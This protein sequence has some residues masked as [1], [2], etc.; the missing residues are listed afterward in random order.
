MNAKT[1]VLAFMDPCVLYLATHD[2][3]CHKLEIAN[4]ERNIDV[5]AVAS[6][7]D[8]LS[9]FVV[10]LKVRVCHTGDPSVS[11]FLEAAKS[12]AGSRPIMVHMGRFPHTPS[13]ETPTLL[14]ALRGGDI[15]THA[16]R[17]ASGV[18]SMSDGQPVA[19]F[20]DAVDRGVLLDIGHSAT[21]FRFRDARR[22]VAAG[23]RPD[24]VSTDINI[25]NIDGPVISLHETMSKMLVLGFELGEVVAMTTVA[26]ATAIHQEHRYGTLGVGREAEISVLEMVE[27]DAALTDGFEK[28]VA[29]RR[30]VPVGCV[31]AGEWIRATA[32]LL[33]QPA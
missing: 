28:V 7:F 16:F 2:F 18:L 1:K 22:I 12:I 24:T 26:P 9:D 6:S 32:G 15:I 11:P 10:G 31:R 25:F 23:Y 3:I 20:R 4:D 17:G 14:N 30:M 13:I 5:D 21:D 8:T 19:Q 27:G 29:D 33:P